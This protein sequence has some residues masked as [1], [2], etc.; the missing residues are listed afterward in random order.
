MSTDFSERRKHIRVYFNQPD[1]ARC[2]FVVAGGSTEGMTGS[3]IDLS[4]GGVHLGIEQE[5][6][7]R[8]GDRLLLTQLSL[9]DGTTC[10]EQVAMEI[11]WVFSQPGFRRYYLGCR[12]LDLSA[13]GHAFLVDLIGAKLR[14]RLAERLTLGHAG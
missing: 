7:F 5:T 10:G 6:D 8:P 1:E 14:E 4:L 3:V 13:S 11:R 12:F 9:S 2:R